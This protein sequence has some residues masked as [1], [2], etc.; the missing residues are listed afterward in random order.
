M[1]GR[2]DLSDIV[3]AAFA[4][5]AN[6]EAV[7]GT[8]AG[9]G[10]SAG[11]IDRARADWAPSPLGPPVPQPRPYVSAREAFLYA[12]M[13]LSLLIVTVNLT[14][15]V[16]ALIDRW[17]EDPLTP[18]PYRSAASIRWEMAML[19]VFGPVFAFQA[20][21]LEGQ[22]R[23]GTR[24]SAIRKWIGYAGLFAASMALL[25]S[26]VAALYGLLGGALTLRFL[27]KTATVALIAAVVFGFFRRDTVEDRDVV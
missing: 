6:A 26:A 2:K 3:H 25:G 11:E 12:L 8:L 4:A 18:T 17:I 9:A 14:Q 7:R 13:A 20:W 10:W 1:A 15:L 21:R 27:L 19:L 23:D 22:R 24:P 5:G 16:F